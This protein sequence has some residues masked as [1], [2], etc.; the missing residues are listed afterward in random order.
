MKTEYDVR[1][2]VHEDHYKGM[3]TETLRKHF[4]IEELFIAN[5]VKLTYT[6]YERFI[7]GGVLPVNGP[8]NLGTIDAVKADHLL[9][10]RELGAI[11]IGGAGRICVD[12]EVH[13]VAHKEALY[14]GCGDREVSF[15]SLDSANPAKFYLNSAPAHKPLPNVKVGLKDADELHLGAVETS[16]KRIIRKLLVN[17]VVETCQ[18]QMGMTTLLDGSVWNTMP[19]HIHDRRMEAYFYFEVPENQ[20]VCHFMGP[21][22]ETRHL[23]LSNEQAVVSP[24]WSMH[25]GTATASYTFIWG[26]AGENLDYDDMDK[27]QPS[28]LK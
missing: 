5:K 28:E 22:N 19:C 2:A 17:S 1:F 6:H 25:C 8:V 9:A 7:V 4:L 21:E 16:N 13:D 12:G 14:I 15:E 23:W 11:N 20:A 26:M 24:P 18:L 10:R 3:D 27:F